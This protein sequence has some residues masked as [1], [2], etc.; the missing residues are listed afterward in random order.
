[1]LGE[2]TD[3][4]CTLFISL[5]VFCMLCFVLQIFLFMSVFSHKIA[6]LEDR[7]VVVICCLN[8]FKVG[9]E[10][11]LSYLAWPLKLPWAQIPGLETLVL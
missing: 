4:Y 3:P 8:V 6:L 7:N 1:M 5:V 2:N 9:R 10:L 11:L